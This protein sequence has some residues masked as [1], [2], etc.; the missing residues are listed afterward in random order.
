MDSA[1]LTFQRTPIKQTF[2]WNMMIRGFSTHGFP[3]KALEFYSQMLHSN[4]PPDKFTYPFVL[5]ASSAV[6]AI[7]EAQEAHGRAIR[8]GVASDIYIATALVD[9]YSKLGEVNVARQ[10][11]DDIPVKNVV[12]WNA[13]IAGYAFN[14]FD[15][16]AV[17]GF[18]EMLQSGFEPNSSTVVSVLPAVARLE[19]LQEGKFIHEWVVRKGMELNEP[20][21][22]SLIAMYGK[23][24]ELGYARQLFDEMPK[25]NDVSWSAIISVYAQKGSHT[26][27]LNLFHHM[28]ILG[29]NP[30][31]ITVA[32]VLSACAD[33]VDLKQGTKIHGFCVKSGFELDLIVSTALV[34]MYA[35][36]GCIEEAQWAF[37]V[38]PERNVVSWNAIISAYGLQGRGEDALV[39][40]SRMQQDGIKPNKSTFV[41]IISACSHA[42]MMAEGLNCFHLMRRSYN[43]V[44]ETKH[45]ACVVDLLGRAGR[46]KEAYRF[47]ERMPIAPDDVVWGA[48]LGACRIH[49]D[50]VLGELVAKKIFELKPDEPSY[51]VLLANIY[52]A[53]GRWGDA[54]KLREV[55]NERKMKK[56]AGH[57]M[58][59]EAG[60]PHSF[61]AGDFR[62][63]EWEEIHKKMEEIGERLKNEG[64]RPDTSYV[65]HE[66]DEGLKDDR[67]A[68]HS[69]RIALAFGLLKIGTGVPI[70]ITKNLRV[71]G[72]CHTAFKMVSKIYGREIIVRDLN[73]FHRFEGGLCSCRDYW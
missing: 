13:M 62:H 31:A 5:K 26:E 39:M 20:I 1:Q 45:Y 55:M 35:K 30:T 41:S 10:V 66:V 40:F 29:V 68:I 56:E 58:I 70:R 53:E 61:I 34:D 14:G 16:D 71:C 19:D 51:Y 72:D 47:I 42:G 57:S 28:R 73:R 69:E 21:L 37:D 15:S 64:H 38:M 52:A 6:S 48:L 33:L 59:E 11:F 63:P 12:S 36:C 49:K 32:S 2:T 60:V 23:C 4:T 18:R 24:G 44:P 7:D 17:E 65:L 25:K 50:V 8:S 67:L 3:Q 54:Q 9:L 46:L 43:I 27:A 22:N